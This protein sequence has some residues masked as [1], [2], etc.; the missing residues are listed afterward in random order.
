MK[1]EWSL[2]ES[3][4]N[5]TEEGSQQWNRKKDEEEVLFGHSNN[6]EI[7]WDLLAAIVYIFKWVTVTILMEK[8]KAFI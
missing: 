3:R 8:A 2:K 1:S 6:T 7:G 5:R 4:M